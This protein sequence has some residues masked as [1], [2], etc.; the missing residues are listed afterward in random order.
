MLSSQSNLNDLHMVV[1]VSNLKD[2]D[3]L[4]KTKT[5][6]QMSQT[7]SND[8]FHYKYW[9]IDNPELAKELGIST[10]LEDIGDVYLVRKQSKYT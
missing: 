8:L 1:Y 10:N 6:R 3:Q 7:N 4:T 9:M 5:F 2:K